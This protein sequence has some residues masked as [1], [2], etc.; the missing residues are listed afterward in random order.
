MASPSMRSTASGSAASTYRLESESSSPAGHAAGG[1]RLEGERPFTAF[2]IPPPE[3]MG[4]PSS[5]TDS[6]CPSPV[7]QASG[8]CMPAQQRTR[9]SI[10]CKAL[11][12]SLGGTLAHRSDDQELGPH[13][14]HR[15]ESLDPRA[16]SAQSRALKDIRYLGPDEKIFDLYSWDE[17]IQETGDGGKVVICKPKD[18]AFRKHACEYVM[19][20]RSKESLRAQEHQAEF[21]R[22]QIRML[23][24]P[25]HVGVM[26]LRE[27]LEDDNFYYMIM[28]KAK[29]GSF[30]C[31]LLKDFQDGVMPPKAIK[32]LM[33]EILEAV[34]HVHQ[35][36][37]LH[38]DIK[39]DNL[40]MQLHDD[41]G[42]PGGRV[43][44]VMLIDFDHADPDFS[45][46]GPSRHTSCYGTL[47]FNAPETFRGNYSAGSDLYSVGTILYLL[48]TGKMPYDDGIFDTARQG[49]EQSPKNHSGWMEQLYRQLEDSEIDWQCN[50][51]PDQPECKRF[52]E[53]LLAFDMQDR[54][55]S[56]LEALGNAWLAAE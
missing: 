50:P 1:R 32:Q 41:P 55:L 28:E 22:S 17:V 43:K 10:A 33:R 12:Q 34:N 9:A 27:V 4:T 15:A 31:A 6:A 51:W 44:K 39:P 38:R 48:M 3:D 21:R 13:R 19:K 40:V 2:H 8:R 52:C 56:A 7:G 16:Q 24:F 23:N 26:P 53:A 29:G 25:P 20:I 14:R 42:S 46:V 37:M 18:Q 11:L 5:R 49:A 30:F 36:G 47:R 45:P 54:P 35:Q